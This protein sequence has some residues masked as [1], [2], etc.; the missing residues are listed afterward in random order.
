MTTPRRVAFES[1]LIVVLLADAMQAVMWGGVLDAEV[2]EQDEGSGYTWDLEYVSP[3]VV[4]TVAVAIIA[5][6]FRRR[7]PG[8]AFFLTLPALVFS[9]IVPAAVALYSV[10]RA[11]SATMRRICA[12]FA[13]VFVLNTLF[14]YGKVVRWWEPENWDSAETGLQNINWL[15]SSAAFAAAPAVLGLLARSRERRAALLRT[16]QRTQQREN[17]LLVAAALARERAHLAREMHDVVSHQ[18]SLIA[19]QSGAMQ[20]TLADPD[21]R[22]R[23]RVIRTLCRQTLDE[24]RQ[25]VGVLRAA[26]GGSTDLAPQPGLGDLPSLVHRSGIDAVLEIGVEALPAAVE[27]TIYRTVQESLTNVRKH[28]PG[29]RV[30]IGIRCVGGNIETVVRNTPGSG[31]VSRLPSARYGLRGIAERAE[32]LNGEFTAGPTAEGGFIVHLRL[33]SSPVSG[34]EI[35]DG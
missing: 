10:A 16:V 28:A 27:R 26:G 6:L 22:D 25:M 17:E 12:C 9:A 1:L 34:R 19:V 15:V 31:P 30:S 11:N 18:V 29:A 32:Y 7:Y 24:L 3:I 35:E 5:V 21:D 8:T 2:L 33:P 23:A 13:V 14:G 4:A 20:V